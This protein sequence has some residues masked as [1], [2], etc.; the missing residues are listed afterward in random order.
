MAISAPVEDII[1]VNVS[2]SAQFPSAPGFSTLLVAGA[3][4]RLPVGDRLRY[5]SSLT[6][7]GSDF[8]TSDDE[9]IAASRWF[10]QQPRPSRIGIG[11]RFTSPVPA[12]L[13]GAIKVGPAASDVTP[14]N[15]ITTGAL[16]ITIN[17]AAVNLTALDFSTD[18]TLNAVAARITTALNSASSG[19]SIIYTGNRFILRSGTTG[20]TSTLTYSGTPASGVNIA[21]LLGLRAIDN[22][23]LTQG[24]AAETVAESL[25]NLRGV[26]DDWYFMTLNSTATDQEV[27]DAAEWTEAQLK[28]HGFTTD[29]S[30]V[31]DAATTNDI[32]S[33][34]E[35]AGYSRTVWQWSLNTHAIVSLLARQATV[36]YA[37]ENTVITLKFKQEPGVNVENLTT[38]QRLAVQGK[39]GNTYINRGDFA[40]IE[41]GV[42]AN[43]RFIDEVVGLDAF[44]SL[45][46]NEVFGALATA[47][48]KIAQTDQ[49][50]TR[51]TDAAALICEQFVDNGF[52]APAIWR[53]GRYG[54][55]NT[56]DYLS[57]GYYIYMAPVASQSQADREARRAPTMTILL[58]G[59]GAVHFATIN[60]TF[61]R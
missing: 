33:F 49:D 53:G 15:A 30:D 21:E 39:N 42:V 41:Q 9:Y 37:G 11:R 24:Q 60:I 59:S 56:G 2:V 6:D 28:F 19:S 12:E 7:V 8:S 35:A 10:S 5:Y 57:A 40:M 20:P 3:S 54:S 13:M 34:M 1:Q 50:L 61:Q 55:V 48:T 52:L 27:K 23:V 32:G 17:G 51:L 16:T 44:T 22:G 26:S 4:N 18:P 36:D 38:S 31:L 58:T 29:N 43:G 46:Q 25:D 45:V 47:P 14:F